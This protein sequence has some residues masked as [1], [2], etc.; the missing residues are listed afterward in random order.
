MNQHRHLRGNRRAPAAVGSIWTPASVSGLQYQLDA[1][2]L[3]SL[4]QDSARTTAVASDGD[5]VGSVAD[6]SGNGRYAAQATAGA[7]LTYRATGISSKPAIESDGVDDVLPFSVAWG[8][9]NAATVGIRFKAV[10]TPSAVSFDTLLTLDDGTRGLFL[11]LCNY[12]GYQNI[13]FSSK[14]I[15]TSAMVGIN[16]ALD[17]SEHTLVFSHSGGSTTDPAQ[18]Q[19]LLDGTNRTGDLV[20]SDAV[21]RGAT[22]CAIAS[23]AASA[24]H[25]SNARYRRLAVYSEALTLAQMASLATWLEA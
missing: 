24:L 14:V 15:G 7:R 20:A 18:Y 6:Q 23:Y 17:T 10:S 5:P 1:G 2:V 9:A 21:A 16:D 22:R 19:L 8:L 4:H 11:M 3:A 25:L 13:S 12:A